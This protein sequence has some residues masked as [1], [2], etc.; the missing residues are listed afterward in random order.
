MTHNNL[1]KSESGV[2]LVI[3]LIMMTVLTLIGLASKFTSVFEIIL[4]GEKR[5]STD[6][7]YAADAGANILLTRYVNFNPDRTSYD[8]F[9]DPENKNPTN[10]QAKID[11]DPYK[12]EPPSGFGSNNKYA[13]FWVESKGSDRTEMTMK[14]ICTINLNVVRVLPKDESITEVT[15]D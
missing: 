2:V 3:A 4:S 9:T 6:A 11:Y 12:K 15:V 14:S 7:F 10:V 8:P 5:R 1:L 13:Y